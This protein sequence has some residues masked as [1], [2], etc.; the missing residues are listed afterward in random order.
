MTTQ[1]AKEDLLRIFDELRVPLDVRTECFEKLAVYLKPKRAPLPEIDHA[2][3]DKLFEDKEKIRGYKRVLAL[4]LKKWPRYYAAGRPI[5]SREGDV[6]PDKWS[7]WLS[8]EHADRKMNIR[9]V[10]FGK[11]VH[12]TE[13]TT[14]EEFQALEKAR[15]ETF[16]EFVTHLFSHVHAR[17]PIVYAHRDRAK[18][19]L[20]QALFPALRMIVRSFFPAAGQATATQ[21][22]ANL[23]TTIVCASALVMANKRHH[24]IYDLCQASGYSL[25]LQRD[26]KDKRTWV[27]FSS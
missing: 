10:S 3:L 1:K 13:N 21:V 2:R 5:L 8:S 7:R 15:N 12:A 11:F 16:A 19:V 27:I 4:Y 9:F 24:L 22:I 25:P 20:D 17:E 18:S 23:E 14:V 26:K 6:D